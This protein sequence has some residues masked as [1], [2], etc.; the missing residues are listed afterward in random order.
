[1]S[2]Y[3]S[4]TGYIP[5]SQDQANGIFNLIL[6]SD[7]PDGIGPMIEVS[8]NVSIVYQNAPALAC[9]NAINI[10]LDVQCEQAVNIDM[11]VP[12]PVEPVDRY[13]IEIMDE[14][15]NLISD[16]ILTGE[17]IGQN[18]TYTVGHECTE[19]TCSG[20]LSVTDNFAP[21]FICVDSQISCVDGNTAD[22]IGLP[23]PGTATSTA[24]GDQSYTVSGWDA[25][26]D[27][28]LSYTD[29]ETIPACTTTLD[30]I[31]N[32]TWIATD[33]NGNTSF[34]AQSI[35]V[36]R[37]SLDDVVFP[38]HFDGN[39]QPSLDCDAIFDTD[40]EGNPS[41]SVTGT[42]SPTTCHYIDFLYSDTVIPN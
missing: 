18:I 24:N 8:D 28:S 41:T 23:I 10:T 9:N 21:V 1:M 5:G 40:D 11:L 27:V 14:S 15:G 33:A 16:N 7:D 20:S 31:I 29:I 37:I 36:E 38:P 19:V 42:P 26:G 32:R 22:E 25:C 35:L 17:H 3:S 30:K 13:I 4:T 34:C 12:N 2:T 39:D 6:V